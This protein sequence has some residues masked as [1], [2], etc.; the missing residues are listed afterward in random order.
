MTSRTVYIG[1][2]SSDEETTLVI[3]AHYGS[4]SRQRSVDTGGRFMQT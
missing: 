4:K 1:L 3:V 2:R